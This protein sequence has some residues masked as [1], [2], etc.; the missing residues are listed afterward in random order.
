M[1]AV[2]LVCEVLESEVKRNI[3][4]GLP[5][6]VEGRNEIARSA[7]N[8]DALGVRSRARREV[9]LRVSSAVHAAERGV[10]DIADVFCR[11]AEHNTPFLA[12]AGALFDTAEVRLGVGI[13][14]VVSGAI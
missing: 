11:D 3:F 4:G 14:A 7:I 1:D 2:F 9:V 10:S 13:K 8:G 6:S 5:P 12:D